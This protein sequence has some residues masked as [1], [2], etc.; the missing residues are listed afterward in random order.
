M[1][2]SES[3]RIYLNETLER[4]GIPLKAAS[5][6]LGLNHAYLQQYIE[7]GKPRWLPERVRLR[8]MQ[9]IPLDEEKLKEPQQPLRP[10]PSASHGKDKGK[11]DIPSYRELLNDPGARELLRLWDAISPNNRPLALK[12]LH[13]MAQDAAAFT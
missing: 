12:I 8:L 9:L 1:V 11:I 13:T 5:E 10:R 4:E 2:T 3:A 7:Y 6:L